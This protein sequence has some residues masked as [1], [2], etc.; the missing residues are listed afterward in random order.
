VITDV[1]DSARAMNE[2]PFGP[3]ALFQRFSSFDDVM[4]RAN[5]LPFGLASY[6]F[7]RSAKTVADLGA[8][9]D[10]G[11]ISIN[12]IGLAQPETPFGGIK[13]SGYGHEGGIEGLDA[14]LATKFV[15]QVGA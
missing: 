5:R 4:S 8:A 12:H 1:P 15:T 3:L 11:M 13:D 6:A 2:E 10:S 14:Y 9:I 7:A